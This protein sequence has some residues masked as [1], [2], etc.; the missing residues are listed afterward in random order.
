MPYLYLPLE[1]A[2]KELFVWLCLWTV[3]REK[4]IQASR[5]QEASKPRS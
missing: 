1:K 5:I 4:P 3:R 2:V